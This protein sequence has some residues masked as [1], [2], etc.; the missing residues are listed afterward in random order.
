MPRVLTAAVIDLVK[1]VLEEHD[2]AGPRQLQIIP[3]LVQ[4]LSVHV[5]LLKAAFRHAGGV[6][7]DAQDVADGTAGSEDPTLAAIVRRVVVPAG[8]RAPVEVNV[9]A[10]GPGRVTTELVG[11][12]DDTV[13]P[14][15]R[16]V[17]GVTTALFDAS[18]RETSLAAIAWEEA[19]LG[20]DLQGQLWELTTAQLAPL[21]LGNVATLVL[22]VGIDAPDYSRHCSGATSARFLL[23][24]TGLRERPS[25][26]TDQEAIRRSFARPDRH[27]VLFLGAGFSAS[28]DL[29]LGNVMRNRALRRIVGPDG[30]SAD[31]AERF[32]RMVAEYD[33]WIDEEERA[34]DRD[35]FADQLTLERVLREERQLHP[36]PDTMPTLDEFADDNAR[37]LERI[38]PAVKAAAALMRA[39]DRARLVIATVNFDTLLESAADGALRVFATEEE[40]AECVGYLDGYLAEGG[41][42]PLL[43]LHGSITA[44]ESIVA[45]VDQTRPGL[46][47]LR[48]EA[49]ARLH[50]SDHIVPWIYVGYS[51]RDLDIGPLL[52]Q[53][54]FAESVDET[55]V[56]PFPDRAVIEFTRRWRRDG[57]QKLGARDWRARMIGVTADRYFTELVRL[58]A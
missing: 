33:R 46:T 43:K 17:R 39:D 5:E 27:I 15:Y 48:R 54:S 26:I 55:W 11:A 4:D 7:V 51:M 12:A 10:D 37:A 19:P 34:L 50:T 44:R 58:N 23:D 41:D 20:D 8:A 25:W 29:P 47:P 18:L 53:T 40:F 32:R 24:G 38:G 13:N 9:R 52:S 36:P 22:L 21:T 1:A 3:V 6:L 35:A 16:T 57:W 30:S 49:L 2:R 31:Q 14:G 28:S 42:V 56:S 45:N